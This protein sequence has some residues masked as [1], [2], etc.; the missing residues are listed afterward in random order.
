MHL[1]PETDVDG[2]F[3]RHPVP[4]DGPE[5]R[6]SPITNAFT[7]LQAL[8][9]EHTRDNADSAAS[10]AEPRTDDGAGQDATA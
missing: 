6:L 5:V 10:L 8:Y 9:S 2:P 4:V 1:E 3:D 7:K